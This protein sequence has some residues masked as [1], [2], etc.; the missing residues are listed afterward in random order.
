M[1]SQNAF[2]GEQHDSASDRG[3]P[4]RTMRDTG[5]KLLKF[6]L[7]VIVMASEISDIIM[8]NKHLI[9]KNA[10][11]GHTGMLSS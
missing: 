11:P 9:F 4:I 7:S 10:Q 6:P 1:L 8:I 3:Y 5:D 2:N